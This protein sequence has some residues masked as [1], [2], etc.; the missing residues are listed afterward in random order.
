MLKFVSVFYSRLSDLATL[1]EG[2]SIK[3]N[4]LTEI[5]G[6]AAEAY[7]RRIQE[8]ERENKELS[9]K[10]QGQP[11]NQMH[12]FNRFRYYNVTNG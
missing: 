6:V 10:L 3:E 2:G 8:V 4:G 9:R 7:E 5:D 11:L 1:Y 12:S